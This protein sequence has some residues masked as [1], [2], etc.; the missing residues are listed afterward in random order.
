MDNYL[1]SIQEFRSSGQVQNQASLMVEALDYLNKADFRQAFNSKYIFQ[2]SSIEIDLDKLST[3]VNPNSKLLGKA[4]EFDGTRRFLSGEYENSKSSYLKSL[5]LLQP[6]NEVHSSL[7]WL[8]IISG[9]LEDFENCLLY[10]DRAIE[11][12]ER[13]YKENNHRKINFLF[14]LHTNAS[15]AY[16]KIYNFRKAKFHA[17][18]A[19]DYASDSTDD[20]LMV[21]ANTV[22][23]QAELYVNSPDTA[24][25]ILQSIESKIDDSHPLVMYYYNIKGIAYQELGAFEEALV[26]FKKSL[27]YCLEGSILLPNKMLNKGAIGESLYNLGKYNDAIEEFTD[28]IKYQKETEGNFSSSLSEIYHHRALAYLAIDSISLARKDIQSAL[29]LNGEFETFKIEHLANLSSIFIR[30]YEITNNEKYIDSI[31]VT[32]ERNDDIISS[33]RKKHRYFDDVI[34]LNKYINNAYSSNLKSLTKLQVIDPA[35]INY[36]LV[37]KYIEGIKS[38]SLKELLKTDDAVL[39]G[40]VGEEILNKEKA[41]KYSLSDIQKKIFEA[42]Q[43][44]RKQKSD[45]LNNVFVTKKEDYFRFLNELENDFPNYYRFQYE[46]KTYDLET[47]QSTLTI[48][49]A[50]IEYFLDKD[51][52][53]TLAIEK[54][55]VQFIVIPKPTNWA[56]QL[57]LFRDVTSNVAKVLNQDSQSKLFKDFTQSSSFLYEILLTN[58]L[59]KLGDQAKNLKIIPD[60]ELNFIPFG[61]LLEPSSYEEVDYKNLNYLMRDFNIS[62]EQTAIDLLGSDVISEENISLTYAGFAPQY[63]GNNNYSDRLTV[64]REEMSDLPMARSSVIEIAELVSGEAYV[65]REASKNQFLRM[66]SNANILHLSMHGFVNQGN[67]SF[68]KFSFSHQPVDDLY[69]IDIYNLTINSELAVLSACNTGKGKIINGDG[70]QNLARAFR[71]AGAKSTIMSLWSIPDAQTADINLRFFKNL[72]DG[73]NIDKALKNAKLSYLSSA[74]KL[75]SHPFFWAGFIP[76]GQTNKQI[77]FTQIGNKFKFYLGG[78]LIVLLASGLIFR[79]IKSIR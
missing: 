15:S 17:V 30:L 79:T 70:V 77:I 23:A 51:N 38:Y 21:S 75:G 16:I 72:K 71:F 12:A 44:N 54:D 32:I 18:K 59:N 25:H 35:A 46:D 36:D 52:I 1:S 78:G 61:I 53:Y 49:D 39:I 40:R 62:Y 41:I 67:P 76:S 19:V 13:F 28:V 74:P 29:D 26:S 10:Y 27:S 45:S 5:E 58:V 14:S 7:R 64:V 6:Y 66:A 9:V 57:N 47:L 65:S 2:I 20:M 8:A 24:L 31:Y 37:F 34:E 73:Q 11:A 3:L 42:K 22:L 50:V 33:I 4:Y 69:A 43:S 56:K 63:I 48:D 55:K 60:D 68:S